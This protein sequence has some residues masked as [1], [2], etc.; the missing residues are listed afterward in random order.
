MPR[1]LYRI[2]HTGERRGKGSWGWGKVIVNIFN[3][4]TTMVK[5]NSGP[6]LIKKIRYGFLVGKDLEDVFFEKFSY[7]GN[8]HIF[9]ARNKRS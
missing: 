8:K 3:K 4:K 1:K 7:W 5:L 2:I 9:R 6:F